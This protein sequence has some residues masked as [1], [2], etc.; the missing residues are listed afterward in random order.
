MVVIISKQ[1]GRKHI[2]MAGLPTFFRSDKSKE[3]PARVSMII[4][5]ICLRSL[6]MAN[7]FVSRIFKK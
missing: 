1:A 2:K 4:K 3:S 7:I 6:E 5:A